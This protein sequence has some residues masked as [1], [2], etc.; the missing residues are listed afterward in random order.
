MA[1]SKI[2]LV[3]VTDKWDAGLK[4]AQDNLNR[5]IQANDG[6]E[7]SLSG[8][9]GEMSEF[10][11]MIGR[12][13]AKAQTSRGQIREYQSAFERL[14]RVYSQLSESDKNSTFGK[15]L[16][17]SMERLKTKISE[18]QAEFS[19]M[20]G[21]LSSVSSE[22]SSLGSSLDGLLGKF[23]MSV[24]GVGAWGL[25]I[26]TATTALKVMKDA[27]LSTESGVD[28][29]RIDIQLIP[30]FPEQRRHQWFSLKDRHHHLEGSRGVRHHRQPRHTRAVCESRRRED[31]GEL[32]P[33]ACH[34]P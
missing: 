4:K 17:S 20:Q 10:V 12:I 32:R 11:K 6:L 2:E 18:S 34:I 29:R 28:E 8:A 30:D 21:S 27:F 16:S 7:K 26:G 9:S 3:A 5:F 25:A 14:H 1:V 31:Q 24:K 13:D 22:S 23:G 33:A 19:K 15:E